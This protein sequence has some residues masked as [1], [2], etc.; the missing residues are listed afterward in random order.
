ML[1]RDL[2]RA[3]AFIVPYW[4]RLVLVLV[5]SALSTALSLYL[6]LLTR[7]FFDRALI[8]R[9]LQ[10]LIRVAVLFT[11]FAAASFVVNV[12]SGLRYTR[13]SADIL[14]DMRLQMYRHLQRLSPRFHARTRIG[15]VMSR[16][17]NDV[18][19]IQRIAAETALAWVGNV[20]FLCGT[21]VMLA[22][23]DVRLFLVT[24]ASAPVGLWLLARYRTKLEAEIA[25]LRQRS[26][27]I[28]SFLVETLQ[29]V[30]LVVTSNAQAREVSR[31]RERNAAFVRALM[32]MQRLTYLS[33]GLPGLILSGGTGFVFIFGG[34][35]V[36]RGEITVGTFV[37]F[38]AYQMRFLPPLQAL[39]GMYANLAAVRV[40]LRR[41]SQILD[42]PVDVQEPPAAVA[43]PAVRGDVAFEDVTLSFDRGAPALE[44]LSFT[45]R[46]GE[47]LAIV[48]PSGSGKSTIA[49][50]LL[51]LLD[52]DRGVV[53]I[54]GHDL[55]TVRL[56][57][58]RR[59]VALVD[60]EPSILH[61]TIAENIRYARPEATDADVKAAVHQAAL[62][63]FIARLPQGLATV[64]GERG[65]ALSAG[66]RQR[67]AVARAFLTNPSILILDEP[68]A[69]LDPASERQVAEGYE[70]VMR[71]R[72]TIVI[73]HRAELARRADRV[74]ELDGTRLLQP[75]GA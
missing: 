61:A 57:D 27:D 48:G 60:Q 41:V 6:P 3:L 20:L 22:W 4:R 59:H 9:D 8:G 46:A 64:V 63:D 74:L 67:I 69:A 73:T 56:D 21:I 49:D 12:I 31:F 19:E 53:R 37:A 50:L 75:H 68:S 62:D 1:D 52:P 36:I 10:T 55:R 70:A 7:D 28:G 2:R 51:R 66:E 33:G 71:G 40:S 23:L 44:Q 35:R 38:M 15:D 5:L 45:V 17:N 26:A 25:T 14:F 39:M 34:Y 72:T 11:V 54:D 47:V 13:V 24:I 29:A 42:E 65:T 43:L 58:L 16:I 30:K 32:S 18:G